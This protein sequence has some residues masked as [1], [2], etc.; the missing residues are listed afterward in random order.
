MSNLSLGTGGFLDLQLLQT[1][2]VVFFSKA[3]SDSN[4]SGS[5]S[6]LGEVLIRR[7]F[8]AFASLSGTP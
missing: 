2:F 8:C 5:I 1:F 7:S 3:R 6:A 4:D